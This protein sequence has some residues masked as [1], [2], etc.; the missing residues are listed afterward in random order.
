MDGIEYDLVISQLRANPAM[1]ANEVAIAA[2]S[3]ATFEKTF[4]SMAV[5]SRCTTLRSP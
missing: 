5:D 2:S 3:S 4:S 1:T